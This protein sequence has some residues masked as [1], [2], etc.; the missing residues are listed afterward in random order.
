MRVSIDVLGS[1]H[2]KTRFLLVSFTAACDQTTNRD[3]IVGYDERGHT[4]ADSGIGSG[5]GSMFSNES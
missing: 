2:K 5:A 3:P 1:R 4:G